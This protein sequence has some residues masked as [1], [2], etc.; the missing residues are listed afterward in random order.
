MRP[1]LSCI[2]V[3]LP[4]L[5]AVALCALP[6]ANVHGQAKEPGGHR[7]SDSS[8]SVEILTSTEGVDFSDFLTHFARIVKRNWYAMM[9]DS[10]ELGEKGKVVLRLQVQRD[11]ALLGQTPTVEISSGRSP[12]TGARL[13]RLRTQRLSS[14]CRSPF[15]ARASSFALRSSTTCR[16]K[17][18]DLNRP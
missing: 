17:R 18:N 6:L 13:P 12:W 10:A 15:A 14:V 7:S 5:I 9:P 16:R 2:L 3:L 4:V 1:R 8:S 11:G